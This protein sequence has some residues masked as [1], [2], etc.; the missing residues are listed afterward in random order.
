MNEERLTFSFALLQC[1]EW[2]IRLNLL[3]FYC[4]NLL[5]THH[6]SVNNKV[7]QWNNSWDRV[8]ASATT[9]HLTPRPSTSRAGMLY[10]PQAQAEQHSAQLIFSRIPFSPGW[11]TQRTTRFLSHSLLSWLSNTAHNSFLSHSLLSHP[12]L[13]FPYSSSPA[14]VP[15]PSATSTSRRRLLPLLV[16]TDQTIWGALCEVHCYSI[17]LSLYW[18]LLY[19]HD[20]MGLPILNT[21]NVSEWSTGCSDGRFGELIFLLEWLHVFQPSRSNEWSIQSLLNFSFQGTSMIWGESWHQCASFFKV[22]MTITFY[23]KYTI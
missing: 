21:H 12:S 1:F 9:P 4:N 5:D 10:K 2:K 3:Y 8:H 19:P 23:E 18:A 6:L 11:A 15:A 14:L 22:W 16:M 7:H 17:C 13:A 20:R